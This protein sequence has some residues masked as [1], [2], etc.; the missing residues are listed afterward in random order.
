MP[1]ITVYYSVDPLKAAIVSITL[2]IFFLIG[3]MGIVFNLSKSRK[4]FDKGITLT[5][6]LN[7]F[8]IAIVGIVLVIYNT[9]WFYRIQEDSE[10]GAFLLSNHVFVENNTDGLTDIEQIKD[11]CYAGTFV[12]GI[13]G[14]DNQVKDIALWTES[15]INNCTV[16]IVPIT[17]EMKK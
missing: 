2:L 16:T 15:G 4:Y 1:E 14:G 5:E 6:S 10:L 11:A 7:A 9:S 3:V 13:Q 12:R 17:E 8:L